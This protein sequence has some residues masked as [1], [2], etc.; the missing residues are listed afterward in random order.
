MEKKR[1]FPGDT[2]QPG[3]GLGAWAGSPGCSHTVPLRVHGGPLHQPEASSNIA[4]PGV[5]QGMKTLALLWN[6]V[7]EQVCVFPKV[8]RVGKMPSAGLGSPQTCSKLCN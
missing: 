1:D 3:A 7:S 4:P 6:L 5:Y 8:W 2:R